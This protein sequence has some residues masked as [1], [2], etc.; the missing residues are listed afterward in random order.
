M[1]P[2]FS[3][4]TALSMGGAGA[5]LA[6]TGALAQTFGNPDRPPEGAINATPEAESIQGP[7][8]KPLSHLFPDAESPPPTDVGGVPRF[9]S[10]FEIASRRIQAGG[11]ARQVTQDDFPASTEV[12][13]V[14]MRLAAGGIRELHWHNAGEWAIMTYGHC[15]VTVLDQDGRLWIGDVEEGDLWFFPAGFPHSLQGLGP[16][17][18]EFVIVFDSGEASEFDTTLVTD[19]FAHTPPEVLA[20]N[21]NL[22][23]EAF[24]N[25]PLNDLWIFQGKIAGSVGLDQ[26]EDNPFI[27]QLSRSQPH[28]ENSAGVIHLADSTNFKMSTTIAAALE[29]LKPGAMRELHWHPNADEWQYWIKGHGRVGIFGAGPKASTMDFGPGDLALVKRNYGHYVLNTGD[30]DVIFLAVFR[31]PRYMEVS[32]AEWIARLPHDLVTQHLNIPEADLKKI[33]MQRQ[34][35][36]P[37]RQH[38][39]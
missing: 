17:G 6:A 9:W 37:K 8:N 12:S 15:R 32:L 29:R 20:Q 2:K 1:D 7:K 28:V 38:A 19:W 18:C 23:P 27:F 31:A 21:F 3:R 35:I 39:K 11:W 14:N 30:E 16:D 24:K 4:R 13:G 5:T 34:E 25:V 26:S 36:V 10:S 22:P 33:A